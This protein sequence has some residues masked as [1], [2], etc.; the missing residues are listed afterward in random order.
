[1]ARHFLNGAIEGVSCH[2]RMR[3]GVMFRELD[4]T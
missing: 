3:W 1:M 2:D 4:D